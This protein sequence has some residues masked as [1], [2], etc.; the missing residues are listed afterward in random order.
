MKP[1][2]ASITI[3][4]PLDMLHLTPIGTRNH[5]AQKDRGNSRRVPKEDLM[6]KRFVGG[7]VGYIYPSVHTRRRVG[8]SAGWAEA[9]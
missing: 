5:E 7:S 4:R 2:A 8:G 3:E 9:W 1:A 6:S